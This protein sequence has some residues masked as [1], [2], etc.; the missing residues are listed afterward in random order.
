[1]L[2]ANQRDKID[3][4]TVTRTDDSYSQ[5]KKSYQYSFSD[6]AEIFYKGGTE[7]QVEA[8]GMITRSMDFRVRFALG[9]YNETMIILWRGEYYNI[10]NIDPDRRRK[11]LI[12]RTERIA[13]DTI[14][15]TTPTP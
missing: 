3:I 9:R 2:A 6:R 8:M 14:T 5:R 13:A 10:R 1:M 4:Y 11:Y 12:L 7:T 15:I